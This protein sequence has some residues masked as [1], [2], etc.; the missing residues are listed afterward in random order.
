ADQRSDDRQ[1]SRDERAEG[2]QQDNRRNSDTDQLGGAIHFGCPGERIAVVLHCEVRVVVFIEDVSDCS[3]R[4]RGYLKDG[5]VVEGNADGAGGFIRAQRGE[6][7]T[8][9]FDLRLRS[10]LPSPSSSAVP[11]PWRPEQG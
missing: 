1:A 10:A 9:G 4:V 11:C 6:S 8:S 2:H 5:V 7:F 3:A